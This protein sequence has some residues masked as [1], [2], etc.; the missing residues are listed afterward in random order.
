VITPFGF[1]LT[2][3]KRKK[4]KV[5]DEEEDVEDTV[6]SIHNTTTFMCHSAP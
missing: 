4:E 3:K 6:G 2:T 1:G 5:A